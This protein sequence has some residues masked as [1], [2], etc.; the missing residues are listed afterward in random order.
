MPVRTCG[1][2]IH[3]WLLHK[4]QLGRTISRGSITKNQVT[5]KINPNGESCTNTINRAEL[6]A[7]HQALIHP[8]V[9]ELGEAIHIYT[10]SLC[11]IYMIRRILDAPWTLRESKHYV[12][13][14][15]ILNALLARAENGGITHIYKVKSHTGIKG[16][17]V[18][19][20]K[21]KEAATD[22]SKRTQIMETS[23]NS[24][25]DKRTW[26]SLAPARQNTAPEAT[27]PTPSVQYLPSLLDGV[28]KAIAPKHSGGLAAKRGV[29]ATAWAMAVP[30]THKPSNAHMWKDSQI[31]WGQ[32]MR[33]M[34]ARWGLLWNQK[35]AYR[36]KRAL[37]P[38]C[39]LCGQMDSIGHMLGGCSHVEAAAMKIARHDQSV[40]LIQ[41][42]IALGPMGGFYMIMDAGK[43]CDLPDGVSGKRVPTWILPPIDA[44]TTPEARQIEKTRRRKMRPD[45][46]ILEGLEEKDVR[47]SNVDR[48][49]SHINDLN[50]TRKLRIHVI[51]VGYCSDLDH[52]AKDSDKRKQHED[53]VA[54]L[55]Q[56]CPRTSF[57]DPVTLGR[58]GTIPASLITLLKE[59]FGLHTSRADEYAKKLNRHAVQW[60]DKMYTHRQCALAR[61]GG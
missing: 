1:R 12:L 48:I 35:L 27:N 45:I 18:A 57:H 42:A 7:I 47:G 34:K 39:P 21:A 20:K 32:I 59:T 22:P 30:L 49:R 33:T 15:N 25:Y 36:C 50:A 17:D 23:D 19:D 40:K 51:E 44:N 4:E 16:N 61:Q 31:K 14:Q 58:C 13:L 37:S 2:G 54:L 60:V 53:L 24:P 28:K 3:R 38:N 11:S 8:D 43:D 56:T 55:R 6:A 5:L 9:A 52:A 26:A 10:D 41:K 29:F 46:L